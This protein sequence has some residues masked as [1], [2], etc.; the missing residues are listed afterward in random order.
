[1][2]VTVKK[3]IN[4]N[5]TKIMKFGTVNYPL[6]KKIFGSTHYGNTKKNI[7]AL[8]FVEKFL[9]RKTYEMLCGSDQNVLLKHILQA[10]RV[11]HIN[12]TI[13]A[14]PAP[15]T[16]KDIHIVIAN[17]NGQQKIGANKLLN[18]PEYS[19]RKEITPGEPGPSGQLNVSGWS[20]EL[21][22]VV[23]RSK[24]FHVLGFPKPTTSANAAMDNAVTPVYLA[25][26]EGHLE[27]LQYLVG[28][29]NGRLD[30][31]AKDGMAPIHASAQ[32]GC[33]NCIKWMV[34]DQGVDLN[35]RDGDGATPLHFAASRGHV[36]TVRWLLKKGAQIPLDK[37]GKSPINDA[38]DNDHMEVLQMLVQHGSTPDYATDSDSADSGSHHNA[39]TCH[40]TTRGNRKNSECSLSDSC[41]SSCE[42]DCH[43]SDSGVHH[44]PFYLHPPTPAEKEIEENKNNSFYNNPLNELKEASE[45]HSRSKKGSE[46]SA[47][48]DDDTDTEP[49]YLHKP[50]EV[51]YNRVQD[52]FG[53]QSVRNSIRQLESNSPR[54]CNE[55]HY[56]LKETVYSVR[57]GYGKSYS[58]ANLKKSSSRIDYE[59]R[60]LPK[61]PSSSS[62]PPQSAAK[63]KADVHSSDDSV[64]LASG[65]EH[66]YEDI[67]P[68]EMARL[69]QLDSDR[70]KSGLQGSSR[71]SQ[72]EARQRRRLQGLDDLI[73]GVPPPDYDMSSSLL[74]DV[75]AR[76]DVRTSGHATSIPPPP[77]F[78]NTNVGTSSSSN[79]RQLQTA[80]S[81]P[82]TSNGSSS[83]QPLTRTTSAPAPPPPPPPMPSTPSP[84]SSPTST[85]KASSS[86]D[87][88]SISSRSSINSSE[89]TLKKPSDVTRRNTGS[90]R[91][92][93]KLDRPMSLPLNVAEHYDQMLNEGVN[94]D[95]CQ[96]GNYSP[97]K[98]RLAGGTSKNFIPPKFETNPEGGLIK[99]SEYLKSLGPRAGPSLPNLSLNNISENNTSDSTDGSS[100]SSGNTLSPTSG[101]P[102]IPESTE[103]DVG[104]SSIVGVGAPPPPPQPPAPPTPSPFNT[105]KNAIAA[106]SST[107]TIKANTANN[108][109]TMLPTISVSDLK[110]VQL[111]KTEVKSMKSLPLPIRAG[112]SAVPAFS[113]QKNDVIAEL[114]MSQDVGGVRALKTERAKEEEKI[115]NLETDELKKVFAPDNFVPKEYD[116][117]GNYIPEW[118]R[119]MLGRRAAEK[120]KKEAQ[121]MLQKELEAKRLQS[122]PPWKRQLLARQEADGKRDGLSPRTQS[123]V[124]IALMTKQ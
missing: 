23:L 81:M 91:G 59:T 26:Q 106:S 64:S 74:T 32:M 29:A 71:A 10:Q 69:R 30:L 9:T 2:T 47:K 8:T 12:P 78:D 53:N 98:S 73:A 83:H 77:E 113:N 48:G 79:K 123:P 21:T 34:L 100:T 31:P 24:A 108:S 35:V 102:S 11:S 110:S 87:Y 51:I 124:R 55:N 66:H 101:L 37:Y 25:A 68:A 22:K 97:T 86:P 16:N 115:T 111:K 4:I 14:S 99:P 118:K 89:E 18:S 105:L 1:M 57:N 67:D 13:I 41:A 3:K 120:A 5:D 33:L 28:E 19:N 44:E 58:G 80:L 103:E 7:I 60:Q 82:P 61:I 93:K 54:S 62:P 52:L 49:F 90:L 27:V 56:D 114:K 116:N 63:V 20:F 42:S 92:H 95:N 109:K 121:E 6:N 46:S 112:M 70:R 43:S 72:E 65:E 40:Q 17:P 122:I 107:N 96:D 76:P 75:S 50:E 84:K 15:R 117:A 36:E 45:K 85:P 39:C 104:K 94:S 88:S 38:A 119:Q